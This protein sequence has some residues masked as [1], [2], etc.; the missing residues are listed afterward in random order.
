LEAWLASQDDKCAQTRESEGWTDL[1]RTGH[2][3][4][5]LRGVPER[6]GEDPELKLSGG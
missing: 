2:G 3:E 5:A 1:E 6:F 4:V